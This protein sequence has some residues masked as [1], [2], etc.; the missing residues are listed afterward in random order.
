MCEKS[1]K[2]ICLF[3]NNCVTLPCQTVILLVYVR[4]MKMGEMAETVKSCAAGLCRLFG[5]G[6]D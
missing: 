1:V 6:P 2:F 5:D 4:D 3:H